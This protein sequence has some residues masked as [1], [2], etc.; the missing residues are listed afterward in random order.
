MKIVGYPLRS[1]RVHRS[2]V[3]LD[4]NAVGLPK[5]L[6]SLCTVYESMQEHYDPGNNVLIVASITTHFLA[7]PLSPIV[8]GCSPCLVHPNIK[9][10]E[11]E[12]VFT[13]LA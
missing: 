13:L 7:I 5:E 9:E 6:L 1:Q 12:P 10:P 2:G 8:V 4:R 3:I 11:S